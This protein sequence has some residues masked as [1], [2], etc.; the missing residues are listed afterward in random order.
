[1][2]LGGPFQATLV[3]GSPWRPDHK[4]LP[5]NTCACHLPQACRLPEPR[6]SDWWQ[7]SWEAGKGKRREFLFLEGPSQFLVT[8]PR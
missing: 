1:M 4:P 3:L 5:L 8:C 7:Q 6:V 2:L